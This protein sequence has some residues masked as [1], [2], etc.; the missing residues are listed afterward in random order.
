MQRSTE[1]G[2]KTLSSNKTRKKIF[3]CFPTPTSESDAIKEQTNKQKNFH[4][5]LLVVDI[6]Q[7]VL[8]AS[9]KKS[10]QMIVK[11]PA[12]ELTE[13]RKRDHISYRLDSAQS[14]RAFFFLSLTFWKCLLLGSYSVKHNEIHVLCELTSFEW[15]WT[16]LNSNH[17]FLPTQSIFSSPGSSLH[18]SVQCF[19]RMNAEQIQKGL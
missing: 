17:Y 3:E 15:N 1:H 2:K 18:S 8:I 10:L 14:D 6:I 19:G 5:L 9:K 12:R 13:T 16:K 7:I 11:C 4:L